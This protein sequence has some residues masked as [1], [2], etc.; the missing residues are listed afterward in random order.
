MIVHNLG[1]YKLGSDVLEFLKRNFPHLTSMSSHRIGDAQEDLYYESE[2]I[3]DVQMHN[4]PS[5]DNL[6]LRNLLKA[7]FQAQVFGAKPAEWIKRQ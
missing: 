3:R 4:T 5:E 1:S 2:L 7:Y 6:E